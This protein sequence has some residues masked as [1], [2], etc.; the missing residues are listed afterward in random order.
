[1]TGEP[2]RPRCVVCFDFD[3]TLVDAG[4]GIHPGDVAILGGETRASLVPA[5]GR[6]LHAVRHAL[7]RHGLAAG[8]PIPFP[9]ILEGG[10][11]VYD[12]GE[13]ELEQRP[14]E[15]DVEAA[16]V[17]AMLAAP[18]VTFMLFNGG[19]VD[20]LW[21]SEAGA[22]MAERFALDT[23]PFSAGGRAPLRKVVA[24]AASAEPLRAFAD[25]TRALPLERSFSLATVLEL[26]RRGVDKASGLR[27]LLRGAAP[28]TT[29]VAAGDGENDLPLFD[30]ADVSFAPSDSPAAIRDRADHVIDLRDAGL[31]APILR[32]LGL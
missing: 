10:A 12:A 30:V 15:A 26:T 11:L 21:P 17:E 20:M 18:E 31:L 7:E 19:A 4:G 24:V 13:R 3:G 9:M 22:R 8:G 25:G 23:R 32:T 1:V 2:A 29:V 6:P 14:F 27:A 28:G 16:L 5:T